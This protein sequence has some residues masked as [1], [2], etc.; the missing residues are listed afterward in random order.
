MMSHKA[1]K[2]T[3]KFHMN[4]SYT[5]VPCT[6]QPEKKHQKDGQC[7]YV[8]VTMIVGRKAM[9]LVY[10]CILPLQQTDKPRRNVKKG[11]V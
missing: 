11:N 6:E 2:A 1:I 7:G 5:A 10:S 8:V 4:N 9:M 3:A